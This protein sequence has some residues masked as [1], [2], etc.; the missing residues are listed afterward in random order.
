MAKVM[1]D[2]YLVDAINAIDS[3]FTRFIFISLMLLVGHWNSFH[4]MFLNS[5][6]CI[7]AQ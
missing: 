6:C 1:P 4:M 7:L 2:A 3:F 5:L